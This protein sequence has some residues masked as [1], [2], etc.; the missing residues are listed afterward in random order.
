MV[1]YTCMGVCEQIFGNNIR[2]QLQTT[3]SLSVS[4]VCQVKR[5]DMQMTTHVT[6][7]V[8]PETSQRPHVHALPSL[9]RKK[10]RDC[11]QS[12]GIF[13]ITEHNYYYKQYNIT[14]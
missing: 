6:E 1:F 10:K 13:F 3:S 7:G 2:K 4:L 5:A 12:K 14:E 9:H 11:S 8:R